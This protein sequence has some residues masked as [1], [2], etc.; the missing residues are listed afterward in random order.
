MQDNELIRTG[1][2]REV[3]DKGLPVPVNIGRLIEAV[4]VRDVRLLEP[5][6]QLL[7]DSGLGSVPVRLSDLL[8]TPRY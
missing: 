4:V 5:T 7:T 8:E 2:G 1:W 6:K 3:A